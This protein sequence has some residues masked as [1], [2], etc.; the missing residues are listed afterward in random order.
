MTMFSQ[1][2]V[3]MVSCLAPTMA[4]FA[5]DLIESKFTEFLGHQPK[6]YARYVDDIFSIFNSKE[7]AERF[8]QFLNCHYPCLKFTMESEEEGVLRFLDTVI[9][10][11]GD[12]LD[13]AWSIKDTNTGIYIP[14]SAYAP[15]RYKTA[16]IRALFSR[17]YRLC[18][19]TDSY[20][21]ACSKIFE[22]FL[23]NGYQHSL[24]DSIKSKVEASS[25]NPR[26][27]EA[28]NKG[29][30]FWK[31]P[32]IE[33][34]E[35]PLLNGIKRINSC[36]KNNVK[37]VACFTTTKTAHFFKNKDVVPTSLS[38]NIVYEFKCQQCD[39]CYIGETTRHLSTRV[40]EHLSGRPSPSEVSLHQHPATDS[41]FRVVSRSN[42]TKIC[43]NIVI[44]DY[45]FRNIDLLNERDCSTPIYLK[46]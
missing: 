44:S 31:F 18:S 9:K 13:Y 5:L 4:S 32:F 14:S 28:D 43:E 22:I 37:L 27:D 15:F 16:A 45:K 11:N 7:N 36:L 25:Q 2:L 3:A 41:S 26:K 35:K 20:Q 40:K 8:L 17:A 21:D 42:Y 12:S 30:I 29:K 23:K 46:L 1:F 38:S 24:I 39:S 33:K 34:A 6:Y 10:R 19:N